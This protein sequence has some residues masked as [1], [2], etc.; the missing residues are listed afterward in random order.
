MK[1]FLDQ[2]VENLFPGYFSLAMATGI[3][4]V[5]SYHLEMRTIARALLVINIAAYV[6]LWSLTLPAH[7]R[8]AVLG[9]GLPAWDVYRQYFST[10]KSDQLRAV[11]FY[12]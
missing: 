7:L 6:V 11:A 1:R 10:F 9:T 12:H 3:I 2:A 5:A 8:P 4:S